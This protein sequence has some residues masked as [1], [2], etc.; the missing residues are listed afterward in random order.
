MHETAQDFQTVE[1]IRCYVAET[2]SGLESLKSDQYEVTQRVLYRSGRPC[3]VHFSLHGP[4]AL[5]LSAI[6]ETE[7]N[8]ILF[9]GSCGRRMLRTKLMNAPQLHAQQ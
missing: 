5:M 7:Q 1:E 9:Y 4:R 6:W 3:G 8:R 2:L